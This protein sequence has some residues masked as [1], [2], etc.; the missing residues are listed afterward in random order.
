MAWLVLD[1]SSPKNKQNFKV[2]EMGL[3]EIMIILSAEFQYE[4]SCILSLT[5]MLEHCKNT[6][7]KK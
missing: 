6:E 4:N 5:A 2:D 1:N 7:S 3:L